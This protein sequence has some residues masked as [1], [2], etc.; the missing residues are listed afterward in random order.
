MKQKTGNAK[1]NALFKSEFLDEENKLNFKTKAVEAIKK[2]NKLIREK[3][4]KNQ[5]FGNHDFNFLK[6]NLSKTSINPQNEE[7]V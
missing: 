2:E 3:N 5:L 7:E 1:L 6:Y 4:I